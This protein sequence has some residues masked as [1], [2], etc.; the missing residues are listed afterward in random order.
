[1]A[2]KGKQKFTKEAIFKAKDI[3]HT[4]S[5][6]FVEPIGAKDKFARDIRPKG[7]KD[8]D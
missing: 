8:N 2:N 6:I 5:E 7:G 1:M 4:H 3:N